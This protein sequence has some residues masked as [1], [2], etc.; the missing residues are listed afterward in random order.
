[1]EAYGGELVTGF[2]DSVD[3]G[4]SVADHPGRTK[5]GLEVA[6]VDIAYFFIAWGLC[7]SLVV[8]SS[9]ISRRE[10]CAWRINGWW[11]QHPCGFPPRHRA[12]PVLEPCSAAVGSLRRQNHRSLNAR[13]DQC[14]ESQHVPVPGQLLYHRF[15]GILV[16]MLVWHLEPTFVPA[17]M[18][19][20]LRL[21]L[22]FMLVSIT[23]KNFDRSIRGFLVSSNKAKIEFDLFK[24]NTK[25][26]EG[27]EKRLHKIAHAI[28]WSGCLSPPVTHP[29]TPVSGPNQ[30]IFRSKFASEM[31]EI[32]RASS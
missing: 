9:K 3:D 8:V 21:Y 23:W 22:S 10:T 20:I 32:A 25:R 29:Y 16:S 26:K 14:F 24:E 17:P 4:G 1:M 18:M 15:L 12:G 19:H 13:K 5:C 7:K 30:W 11:E 27:I 28:T 2:L 6:D 31:K